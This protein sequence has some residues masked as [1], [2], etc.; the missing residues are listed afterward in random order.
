MDRTQIEGDIERQLAATLPE[1]DLLEVTTR[2][3]GDSAMLK[4]V[5]DHP[6]GVDHDLCVAVTRAL[7]DASMRERYGIEVWSP[8]PERPLRTA[9]H[10]SAAEGRRIKFWARGYEG[11]K[12]PR[13][14][15]LRS[16]SAGEI[17]VDL[18]DGPVTIALADVRRAH[19]A[20][21]G[22]EA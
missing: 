5:V 1:V 15:T 21:D 20:D 13:T 7:D 9:E 14:G 2:G 6:A 12:R 17:V 3:S 11:R 4:V 16:A 22:V 19:L 18:A 8:G 10:F